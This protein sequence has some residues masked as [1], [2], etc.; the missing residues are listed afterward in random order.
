MFNNREYWLGIAEFDGSYYEFKVQ[1]AKRYCGRSV[2][3]NELHITVA[4]VPKKNGAKC[5]NDDINKFTKGFI[6]DGNITGKLTHTYIYIDD[7]YIDKY[8][9]ETG[10]SVDLTKC[11]YLLD[12]VEVPNWDKFDYTEIEVQ[13]YEE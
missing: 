9:N 12:S 10:D 5:L 13:T 11:D 2:D 3:D 8:G 4:G 7:I 6:F 1:G